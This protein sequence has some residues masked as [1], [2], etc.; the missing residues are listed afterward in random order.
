MSRF[1]FV[2]REEVRGF[3]QKGLNVCFYLLELINGYMEAY[4]AVL[5]I[6]YLF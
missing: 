6:L 5:F 3:R 4:Y 2:G 1:L